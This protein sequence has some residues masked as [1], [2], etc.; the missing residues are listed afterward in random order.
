[1]N[2]ETVRHGLNE[3][4][5]RHL[6]STFRYIDKLLSEAEHNMLD[7]GSPSPFQEYSDDTTP[8]QRKVTHD[9]VVRIRGAM[10]RV[11]EELDLPPVEARCGAVWAASV[12]LMFCSIS[13]NELTPAPPDH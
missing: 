3:H 5:R 13:L 9:Y 10:R 1:M 8:V 12:N 7:A 11:M 2:N 4:H 6:Q